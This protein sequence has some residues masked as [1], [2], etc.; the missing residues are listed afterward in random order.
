MKPGSLWSITLLLAAAVGGASIMV[1]QVGPGAPLG[2]LRIFPA[3]NPW[4]RDI[5]ADPIDP[6]S[7]K[8][9]ARIGPRKPLHPDFG[10]SSRS[11]IP[12]VV[13]SGSLPKVPIRFEYPDESDP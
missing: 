4:N 11:G 1:W 6:D 9:L 13:V 5:S 8:I 12:Y 10:P 2:R 3:D 7:D